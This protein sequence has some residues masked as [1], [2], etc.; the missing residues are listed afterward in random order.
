MAEKYPGRDLGWITELGDPNPEV[1]RS[2]TWIYFPGITLDDVEY[3]PDGTEDERAMAQ[4]LPVSTKDLADAGVDF[5]P[6][7]DGMIFVWAD[8]D[9]TGAADKGDVQVSAFEYSPPPS[10]EANAAWEAGFDR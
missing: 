5:T 8:I 9:D 1:D 4:S 2:I 6:D 10:A 7:D 3:N